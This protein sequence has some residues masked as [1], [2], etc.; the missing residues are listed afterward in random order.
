VTE[1]EEVAAPT[2]TTVEAVAGLY[3]KL[4]IEFK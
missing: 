4:T 2:F 3:F 1:A